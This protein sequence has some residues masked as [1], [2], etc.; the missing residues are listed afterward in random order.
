[1]SEI[2]YLADEDLRNEIV[3]ACSVLEP[4]IEFLTVQGVGL[5]GAEDDFVLEFAARD[6][7]LVVSHDKRT[8]VPAARHRLEFALPMTGL[9]L[10]RQR[11]SVGAVAED[12]TLIW[13][14]ESAEYWH[15]Q[16]DYLPW[17][18]RRPQ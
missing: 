8:M 13:N 5:S 11:A 9:F 16:I 15:G 3:H 17:P 18:S 14:C 7:L 4:M 1:M 2:R 6:G 12:L 10:V